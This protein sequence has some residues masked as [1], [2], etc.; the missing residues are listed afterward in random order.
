MGRLEDEID[1]WLRADYLS[2]VFPREVSLKRRIVRDEVDFWDYLNSIKWVGGYSNVWAQWQKARRKFDTVLIDIDDHSEGKTFDEQVEGAYEALGKVR[3]ILDSEGLVGRWY[4][5]GRGFHVYIDFPIKHLELYTEVVRYQWAKKLFKQVEENIDTTV[6][7]NKNAMARVPG[8]M[9]RKTKL[10]MIRIEPEWELD[11]I[12]F[13]SMDR[14]FEAKVDDWRKVNEWFAEYLVWQEEI[15]KEKSI[16]RKDFREDDKIK[17][18]SDFLKKHK[19]LRSMPPCV[20]KGIELLIE[21]GELVHEWRFHIAGY[22]LRVW[23]YDEVVR[24]FS[25]ADDFSYRITKYQLDYILGR[26]LYPYS[27]KNAKSLGICPMEDIKKCP[28]Y[29]LTDGWI[30][31][32]LKYNGDEE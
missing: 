31:R 11:K 8:T 32:P 3:D 9:N 30:G 20:A 26:D 14:K 29:T 28:W 23:D 18:V 24:V 2:N 17:G 22:L 27:C 15:L 6:I 21:A 5:S 7:G 10:Y 1:V 12:L 19:D 13:N 16:K 4:F 25:F